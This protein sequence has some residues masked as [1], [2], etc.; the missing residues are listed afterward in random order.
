MKEI[1]S[2]VLGLIICVSLSAQDYRTS[3]GLKV[4][5]SNGVSVKHFLSSDMAVEGIIAKNLYKG[6][7]LSALVEKHKGF[8]DVRG[9]N[10]YYGGGGHF[11]RFEG[12]NTYPFIKDNKNA[13]IVIGIDAVFGFEHGFKTLPFTIAV[14]FRPGYNIAGKGIIYNEFGFSARYIFPWS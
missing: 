12:N 10:W 11:Y 4:G 7:G 14:D 6:I 3:A 5:M 13:G 9:V 1:F 2:L 8:L